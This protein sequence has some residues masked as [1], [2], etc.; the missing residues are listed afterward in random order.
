LKSK[1]NKLEMVANELNDIEHVK[2]EGEFWGLLEYLCKHADS[3]MNRAD[4]YEFSSDLVIEI[5]ECI[6][7]DMLKFLKAVEEYGIDMERVQ[8]YSDDGWVTISLMGS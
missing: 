2:K 5:E 6:G 4:W 1:I 8:I 3:I 7:A